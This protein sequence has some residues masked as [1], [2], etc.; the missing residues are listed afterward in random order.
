MTA[1][2]GIDDPATVTGAG[3]RTAFHAAAKYLETRIKLL[4]TLPLAGIDQLAVA[5][6]LKEI[7][8]TEG[9][10]DGNIEHA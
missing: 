7:G 9:A 2:W 5:R 3:Q 8:R 6:R 4:L 10:S 1:H